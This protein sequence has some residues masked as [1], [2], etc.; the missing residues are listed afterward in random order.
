[1]AAR[2]LGAAGGVLS[3]FARHRT[4]ANLL[5]VLM[6]AAGFWAAP[7]M[8]AQFFPDVI[9]DQ[10]TVSVRWEGA[11]PE[12]ADRAIVQLL[13]PALLSVEGVDSSN[14]G[15]RTRLGHVARRR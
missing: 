14:A 5:L 1:M 7:Q 6:I 2:Q 11:G 15:F 9:V 8:R 4:I 3:Y 12:D 10:V 13:E